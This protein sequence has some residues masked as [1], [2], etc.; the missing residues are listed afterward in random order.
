MECHP[1]PWS[2]ELGRRDTHST[3][4]QIKYSGISLEE[5]IHSKVAYT[6]HISINGICSI[7][8]YNVIPYEKYL[9]DC[10]WLPS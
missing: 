2:L 6:S 7:S 9:K 10:F 4:T 1:E 8:L 3:A 5:T